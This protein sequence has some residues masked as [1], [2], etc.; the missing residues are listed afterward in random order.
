[1][2]ALIFP[3]VW[4]LQAKKLLTTLSHQKIDDPRIPPTRLSHSPPH[5][6][7]CTSLCHLLLVGFCANAHA[8]HGVVVL[9]CPICVV[10]IASIAVAHPARVS[11]KAQQA[12]TD[13]ARAETQGGGL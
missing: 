3:L 13:R 7:L 4:K 1:M 8:G 10:M 6:L 11:C 9:L 12:S 5:S 2:G